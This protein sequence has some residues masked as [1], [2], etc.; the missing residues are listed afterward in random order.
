MPTPASVSQRQSSIPTSP[1]TTQTGQTGQTTGPAPA[2]QVAPVQSP[3]PKADG[4]STGVAPVAP[5]QDEPAKSLTSQ[6][7]DKL[8]SFLFD[9][10]AKP[11]SID[12]AKVNL[13]SNGALGIR[14]NE[15]IIRPSDPAVAKDPQRS[16]YE[17]SPAGAQPHVWLQTGGV[18]DANLGLSVPIN[19]GGGVT[20][21]LGFNSSASLQFSM[22]S[23]YAA[24]VDG[25]VDL[26]ARHTIDLPVTAQNARAL[27]QG[28]ELMLKGQGSVGAS[29]SIGGGTNFGGNDVHVG[30]S[31]RATGSV[32]AE[33]E[34]TV[35]VKKLDGDKVFVRIGQVGTTKE[36]VGVRADAGVT[37]DKQAITD[38]VGGAL[39]TVLKGE[40]RDF[41]EK[42]AEKQIGSQVEK[43]LQKYG[44]ASA[45]IVKGMGQQS[46]QLDAYVIDLS[47]P[48]GQRAYD[49]LMHLDRG[50]ANAL[51]ASGDA[52]VAHYS[53]RSKTDSLSAGVKIGPATLFD[54][55]SSSKQR[56]G[57]LRSSGGDAT[58]KQSVVDRSTEWLFAG[59]KHAT[60]EGVRSEVSGGDPQTFLHVS[61]DKH[62]KS[63]DRGDLEKV[64]RVVNALDVK[65]DKADLR[66]DGDGDFGASDVKLDAYVTPDAVRSLAKLSRSDVENA[67]ARATQK[68]EG[69]ERVPAWGD[70]STAAEARQMIEDYNDARLGG[71][72]K[73]GDA[74]QI[75]AQYSSQFGR[76][77]I[78]DMGDLN[79]AKDLSKKM[80]SLARKPESEWAKALTDV[81]KEMKY[82]V[83]RTL[84]AINDLAG[85]DQVLVNQLDVKGKR[86]DVA[87]HS[88][89]KVTSA[90]DELIGRMLSPP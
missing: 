54:F 17:Q 6:V 72:N 16:A 70:P 20:A 69:L 10:A 37:V 19:V 50:P 88:E 45:S 31:A 3:P 33:G 55:K 89:G 12:L 65:L 73:R 38:F 48:Q 40:L 25:A 61:Y 53:E 82:D 76:W 24:S 7:K 49:A 78:D 13:G 90:A 67:Y 22:V 68:V 79:Q 41:L 15:Q 66:P 86:L 52:S 63:T 84:V 60:W 28:S 42:P 5:A 85:P 44:S 57:E 81:G 23:P 1:A 77:I 43:L 27:P 32:S 34:M 46:Q 56:D 4:F 83:Y 74:A 30:V 18:I 14:A 80:E 87:G 9:E 58:V 35:N 75:E 36:Q 51:M 11:H 21:N 39:D 29:A 8:V 62:M 71:K 47:S 2:N 64:Q 59:K 26:A